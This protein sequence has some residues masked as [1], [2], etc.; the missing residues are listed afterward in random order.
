MQ[1]QVGVA[2]EFDGVGEPPGRDAGRNTGIGILEER[3]IDPGRSEHSR[4]L[5]TELTESRNERPDR[6]DRQA[7][8]DV[9]HSTTI[10]PSA[11]R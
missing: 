9:G 8:F 2:G 7:C 11:R 6:A 5:V 1:T 4:R 3:L 10:R